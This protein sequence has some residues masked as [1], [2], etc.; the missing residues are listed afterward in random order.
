MHNKG[1]RHAYPPA[2]LSSIGDDR[3][4]DIVNGK[5]AEIYLLEYSL[6]GLDIA[7]LK[8]LQKLIQ[9]AKFISAR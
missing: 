4:Q 2:T 6:V 9:A 5:N 8:D 3:P 1:A 7:F